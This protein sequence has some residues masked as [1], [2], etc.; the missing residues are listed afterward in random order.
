MIT[1]L[2]HADI[3]EAADAIAC[4]IP[5]RSRLYG[6][7]RGG[8][9]VAYL[10]AGLISGQV[11]DSVEEAD[12]VVDDLVDSGATRVKYPTRQFLA[13]FGRETLPPNTTVGMRRGRG[14]WLVFP[15]EG[16]LEGSA[17]D[18]CTRLLQFI[19]EDP[20]REGLRETPKRFLKAWR[21]FTKGYSQNPADM[22]KV[23]EDGA[24][25][26][27]EMVMVKSI[28]VWSHCEH[29]IVP[30]FG[31]A[32]VAYIPD[33]KV[34]GLSKIPRLVDVFARRLQIQERLGNQV[35]DAMMEH[36]QP[37]GCGIVLRLR[38]LCMESRG[39]E[40]MG[41]ETVTCALRGVFKSNSST[42]AEFLAL[43]RS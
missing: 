43:E 31:T 12:F 19:G 21:H 39:I 33:K 24:E 3:Q 1:H 28:P 14:G 27:D 6:V 9:P 22:M 25:E 38:H 37:L 20:T 18:I 2:T 26:C 8:I 32:T 13:L 41:S 23:F 42:R 11:V 16:T 5:P 17:E 40:I 4:C 10:L 7:P 15:W 34:L 30:V 36:L 35:V 29:H